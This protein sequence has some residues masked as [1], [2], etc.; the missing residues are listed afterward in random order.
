MLL[1]LATHYLYFSSYLINVTHVVVSL[2]IV[3]RMSPKGEEE[4]KAE[5]DCNPDANATFHIPHI[6][7]CSGKLLDVKIK[8]FRFSNHFQKEMTTGNIIHMIIKCCKYIYIYI[9]I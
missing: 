9:Y 1:L 5:L 6:V 8:T 2:C 3:K 4:T 7:E